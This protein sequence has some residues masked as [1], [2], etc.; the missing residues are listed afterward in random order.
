MPAGQPARYWLATIPREAWER[1]QALPAGVQ[2][3]RGQL[4]RGEGEGQFLHWQICF[5]LEKAARTAGA[6]AFLC[7]QAHVEPTRSAAA[8]AYVW[9]DA[10]ALVE[11][12][13]ELGQ[14]RPSGNQVDWEEVV[15]NA[16]LGN[17]SAIPAGVRARC[18]GN[19][20]RIHAQAA[21]PTERATEPAKAYTG[22]TG[23]GK[24]YRAWRKAK[25]FG[26]VYWKSSTTKWWDGYAGEENVIIDE[27]DGQIGIVHLLRWLDVYPCSVEI[28][29]GS[30]PLRATR[31]WITSN[32]SVD[33]W[34]LG[35]VTNYD[36]VLALKR[37]LQE[38]RVEHRADVEGLL[39]ASD[40]TVSSRESE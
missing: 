5:R 29:G 8:T 23:T 38:E 2:W 19:L 15:R 4:E 34:Y 9:K 10:T 18:T 3:M 21:R 33:E 37:R 7:P 1:P 17:W 31:F 12:R 26:P 40:D 35:K 6:K 39:D 27:F 13:F 25:A 28:K 32:L 14:V 22:P 11:T 16:E 20:V 36:Q 24:T 30:T